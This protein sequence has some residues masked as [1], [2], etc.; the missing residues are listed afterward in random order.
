LQILLE[1][2][3]TLA[4]KATGISTDIQL[5]EYLIR[6]TLGDLFARQAAW[7][8]AAEAYEEFLIRQAGDV[9]L[10]KNYFRVLEKLQNWKRTTEIVEL[11]ID[12]EGDQPELIQAMA[13]LLIRQNKFSAALDV[14]LRLNELKPHDPAICKMIAGLYAKIGQP[15]ESVKWLG[16][17]SKA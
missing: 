14:Y 3:K 7:S 8:A 5:E 4:G 2:S 13:T 1:K 6:R 15:E 10:L 9:A 16:T 17:A 12:L 11:I